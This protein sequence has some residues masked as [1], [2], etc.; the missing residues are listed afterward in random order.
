MIKSVLNSKHAKYAYLVPV[1]GLFV[2]DEIL[3]KRLIILKA[4]PIS[5]YEG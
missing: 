3:R 4:S 1:F 5:T 2:L